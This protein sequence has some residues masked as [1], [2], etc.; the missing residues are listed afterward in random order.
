MNS[1]GIYFVAM[2]LKNRLSELIVNLRN[3]YIEGQV[4]DRRGV[5]RNNTARKRINRDKKLHDSIKLVSMN[6]MKTFARISLFTGKR[7]GG[8]PV[9]EPEH[10]QL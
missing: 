4:K 7:S 10:Q 8:L 1:Q 6:V 2:N 9:K 3:I 5:S